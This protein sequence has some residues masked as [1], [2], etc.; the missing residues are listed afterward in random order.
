MKYFTDITGHV[1]QLELLK[2]ALDSDRIAHAYIFTGNEGIGKSKVALGFATALICKDDSSSQYCLNSGKLRGDWHPDLHIIEPTQKVGRVKSEI[3]IDSI[4]E[5]ISKLSFKPHSAKR[6]A[7]IIKNGE[8]MNY[9][10]ANGLL[11][12]LEEPS[13]ETTLI[14]TTS[15]LR[16]LAPTIVSRC[17]I[18]KFNRPSSADLA[19][20]TKDSSESVANEEDEFRAI[21]DK[22]AVDLLL[23]P[24][25][26]TPIDIYNRARMVDKAKER[27]LIDQILERVQSIIRDIVALKSGQSHDRIIDSNLIDR[28]MAIKDQLSLDKLVNSFEFIDRLKRSRRLNINPLIIYG[29]LAMELKR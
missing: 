21:I 26:V 20:L 17:Q 29:L 6:K 10:A 1:K 15:R 28:I 8:K 3:D 25:N 12:T 18:V 22:F 5:L 24:T 13:G 11:K 19:T 2:R 16:A 9:V 7:V 4:R 23:E 14:I 27:E